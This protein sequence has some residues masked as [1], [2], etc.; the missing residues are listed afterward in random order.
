[1]V[2]VGIFPLAAQ[3]S[4][5][6]L[7]FGQVYGTAGF[8]GNDS[9]GTMTDAPNVVLVFSAADGQRSLEL[10]RQDGD[11]VAL[12][13]PGQYCLSAYTRAGDPMVLAQEQLKCIVVEHKEDVRLDVML[14]R[15][16]RTDE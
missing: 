14:V 4:L 11:Y 7:A 3:T 5:S 15:R 6:T 10:T 16:S 9:S 8:L 13:E 1:M 2:F 12:L